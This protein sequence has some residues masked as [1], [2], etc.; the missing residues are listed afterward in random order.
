M[1]LA[2]RPY[3]LPPLPFAGLALFRGDGWALLACRA[4]CTWRAAKESASPMDPM[5]EPRLEFIVDPSMLEV[6]V[7]PGKQ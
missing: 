4:R 3:R 2:V 6:L 7:S 1:L 5:V